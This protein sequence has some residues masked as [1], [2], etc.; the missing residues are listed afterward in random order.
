MS[1]KFSAPR[2]KYTPPKVCKKSTRGPSKTLATGNC[3]NQG[4]LTVM[5]YWP[6]TWALILKESMT[7]IPMT[8]EQTGGCNYRGNSIAAAGQPIQATVIFDPTPPTAAGEVLVGP[9]LGTPE[10]WGHSGL[11]VD[12]AA[13]T[14]MVNQE[15]PG[16][17]LQAPK[18]PVALWLLT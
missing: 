13:P 17:P 11:I 14:I 1:S 8:R 7:T 4:S 5:I 12:A 15:V 18:E 3:P 16:S 10:I 2:P 6:R 9:P